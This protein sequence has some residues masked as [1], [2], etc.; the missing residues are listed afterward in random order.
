[1]R[2]LPTFEQCMAEQDDLRSLCA[3][4][5]LET[6]EIFSPNAYYG[7]D[8]ILKSYAR[9]ELDRPLKCVVPHGVQLNPSYVWE[10]ERLA[11]LPAILCT[12]RD[13]AR[14][15]SRT[16]KVVLEGAMPFAYLSDM[17]PG[18]LPSRQG[19]LFFLS[20][21]THRVTALSDFE[22]L[23][24]ELV[25]L[26]QAFQPVSVC[27]YWRDFLIDHHLAFQKRGLRIVSAGH[28][29]DPF[30]LVR[31]FYLCRTHSYACSNELGSHIFFSVKAGCSYF[32]LGDGAR[33]E[34]DSPQSRHDVS[35]TPDNVRQSLAELFS[36]PHPSP[37]PEQVALA[38][39]VLGEK[40]RASPEELRDLFR[41][42]DRLD[43]YG[44]ASWRGQRR[45]FFPQAVKRWCWR[46]PKAIA[47]AT[48]RSLVGEARVASR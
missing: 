5:P 16:R 12:A 27:I 10:A 7:F 39:H 23:A 26:P 34:L 41:F 9:V 33:R 18:E 28:M 19:T 48:F 3:D 13:V 29:F 37:T 22:R 15:S 25:A 43:R 32:Q 36:Q 14:Y 38:D 46:K 17:L 42:C 35:D 21:S 24:D 20:H 45:F 4:R 11:P 31:L 30:F 47:R 44:T 8:F 6:T 2:E 1:M 40:N